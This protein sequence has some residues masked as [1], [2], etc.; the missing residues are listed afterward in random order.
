VYVLYCNPLLAHV[1]E[2][3]RALK[4]VGGTHQYSAYANVE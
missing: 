1:L 2:G 3:S 4:H